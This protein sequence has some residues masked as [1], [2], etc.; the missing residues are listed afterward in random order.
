MAKP[1][2][3]PTIAFGAF[4]HEST[5]LLAMLIIGLAGLQAYVTRFSYSGLEIGF[6]ALLCSV[7]LT[8]ALASLS[9]TARKLREELAFLAYG[10]S[11][12]QVAMRHF[13]RG[14]TCSLL[15][16]LPFFAAEI[17][18][19]GNVTVLRSVLLLAA[20]FLGGIFYASPNIRRIRSVGFAENY[21]A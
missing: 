1:S 17:I 3:A 13:L 2:W 16:L 12:W 11:L 4:P 14:L 8:C 15:A 19:A 20:G 21:K 5:D 9:N 7:P 18:G 10:G 6:L